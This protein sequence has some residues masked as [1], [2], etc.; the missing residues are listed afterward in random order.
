MRTISAHT[1]SSVNNS[2]LNPRE[3]PWW[4]W[5][6]RQPV[7]EKKDE[8]SLPVCNHAFHTLTNNLMAQLKSRPETDPILKQATEQQ[9]STIKKS[10]VLSRTTK[11]LEDVLEEARMIFSHCWRVN[12][13]RFFSFVPSPASPVSCLGD[14]LTSAFN[15]FAGSSE[16]GSGVCAD[17]KSVV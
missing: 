7:Q 16:A 6:K 15:A 5:W 3:M 13:P 9:A 14:N 2:L 8:D 17:R 10:A 11:A 12:H 1:P 4:R